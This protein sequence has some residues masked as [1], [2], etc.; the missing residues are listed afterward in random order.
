LTG[1][2]AL[3]SVERDTLQDQIYRQL[4]DRLMSGFFRPGHPMSTRSIAAAVG[5]SVMPVRDALRRLEAENALVPGPNRTL[6][7][8]QMSAANLAEI[9]DIRLALEGMAVERAAAA[10][11]GADVLALEAHCREMDAAIEAQ[12]IEAYLRANWA[13]HSRIYGV[14]GSSLLT[15]MIESLWARMGPYIRFAAR[16]ATHFRRAMQA[17]WA[18]AQALGRHDGKAARLGIERDI[19]AAALDL[20][21]RLE[22]PPPR[23][24]EVPLP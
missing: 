24:R 23:P 3:A 7:V 6:M 11:G 13:F 16:D 10:I 19:S 21:E 1:L 22:N 5:A 20:A 4:K 12:D 15:T 9:R 14:L 17:H 8:P 18:I 2:S